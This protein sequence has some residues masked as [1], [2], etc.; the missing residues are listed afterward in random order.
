MRNKAF[1]ASCTVTIF[2]MLSLVSAGLAQAQGSAPA[3]FS[4]KCAACH[5]TDGKGATTVGKSLGIQDLASPAVQ[6][7]SDTDLAQIIVKG[8]NKMPAYGD[9]L[10]DPDI[11]DLVAY[12]RSLAAKK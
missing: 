4:A 3:T 6:G 10:K 2:F 8:K 9:S 11:K 1:R 5:G 7:M 12:I